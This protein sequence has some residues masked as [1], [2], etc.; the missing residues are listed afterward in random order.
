VATVLIPLPDAD[1]DPTE[2]AVSWLRLGQ[3][4]HR[5][6]FATQSGRP[7][8]GDGLMI[9]GRGLDP[10]GFVPGLSHVVGVGRFL[11]ADRRGRAAYGDMVRSEEFLHPCSWDAIDL[12]VADGLLLPGGH[13][14]RGMRPYLESPVLFEVVGEAF[15]RE[16]PVAAVCHGVLLAARS[17]DPATGHSVLY[18]R[19]TTALTWS[20]ERRAWQVARRTRFW[21]PDYY[22]TYGEQP[23]QPTG[24][25]SVQQEVTRALARPED[26]CDVDPG[27]ADASLKLSGRARDSPDDERP[28]F[29]VGDGNYLSARWPGDIHTFAKRFASLLDQRERPDRAPPGG[30]G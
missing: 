11:R 27:Q 7:A 10:W 5:V 29:V 20:L 28:A 16:L 15:R 21:D 9:T 1:F 25:M 6:R 4:G 8:Q 13:R 14:A 26:F 30:R 18:G 23:G 17:V 12:G 24:F 22:R 2:A 19:R 3:F